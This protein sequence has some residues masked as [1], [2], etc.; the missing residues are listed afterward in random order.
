[1]RLADQAGDLPVLIAVLRRHD[2]AHELDAALGIGEGAVLFEE[3]RAGQEDVRVVR[4]LV[5]E[6]VLHDDAFHRR[7]AGGDMVRVWGRTA[8][9]P[10]PGC[11]A[12]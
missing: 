2:L 7:E 3:G 11:R 6:Q 9:C 10:R 5:Q 4:G 12:P 8:G 1:M